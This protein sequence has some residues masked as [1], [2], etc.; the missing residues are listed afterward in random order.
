[1]QHIYTITYCEL[2]RAQKCAQDSSY[3]YL[4]SQAQTVRHSSGIVLKYCFV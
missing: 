2:I 4:Y 3:Y 1:M